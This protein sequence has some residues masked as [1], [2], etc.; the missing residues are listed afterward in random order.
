METF[1]EYN[2]ELTK[3]MAQLMSD[4]ESTTTTD[5]SISN[6][7]TVATECDELIN[8][9]KAEARTME[10]PDTKHEL[11]ER[12]KVYQQNLRDIRKLKE[13][14][15]LLQAP[16]A[17]QHKDTTIQHA[18][19]TLD[20]QNATLEQARKTMQETEEVGLEIQQELGRNRESIA[21]SQQRVNQ[22]RENTQQ[23]NA[24]L[25]NM[26]KWWNR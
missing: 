14:E 5:D 3:L 19:D 23:S 21:S 8:Q 9:M 25:K 20:R 11:L 10:D 4:D 18:E 24:I 16:A 6:T 26:S 13:R 12:V 22:I 2:K 15:D 17:L 1:Q 7:N